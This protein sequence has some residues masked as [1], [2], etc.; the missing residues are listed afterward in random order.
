PNN[1]CIVTAASSG[2]RGVYGA[3]A[4]AG[5]WGLKHGCAVA[6]T[7][8]G[9]GMGVDDLQNNTVNLMDGTPD[10]GTD[11]GTKSNF[12]ANLSDT[13]RAAFKAPRPTRSAATHA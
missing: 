6:Y 2:S 1:P 5:E 3:I 10:V 9:S 11:A 13:D 12:T 7:D 4:T 8:K